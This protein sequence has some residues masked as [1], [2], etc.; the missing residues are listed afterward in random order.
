MFDDNINF[1][2]EKIAEKENHSEALAKEELIEEQTEDTP[3]TENIP[4]KEEAFET[5]P[6]S[7]F[8]IP[9]LTPK[10]LEKKAIK[11]VAQAVGFSFL[12]FYA[13]MWVLNI[14]AIL[15][16]RIFTPSFN[17]AVDILYEPAIAQVQQIVFS[18]SVFTLPFIFIFKLYKYRISDLLSFEAPKGKKSLYLFLIGISFCSFANIAASLAESI[19]DKA[20]ISYEVDFG[21]N[22]KGVFGFLLSFIATAIVPALVE[23]FACRGILLGALKKHGEAFAIITSSTLFGLMHSN[24]E[25]IPFAFLVGLVLGYITIKSGNIWIAVAVHC[26]NNSVSVVYTYLLSGLSGVAQNISYT[27]FLILCLLAGLF[28]ITRL[29][30]ENIFKFNA[31]TAVT[32]LTT[33]LKWFFFSVPIII[34]TSICILQSLAYFN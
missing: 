13:I 30:E 2:E 12:V 5:E 18:L 24:F 1:N 8:K 28:A 14:A 11:K 7:F 29:K 17:E 33:R 4:E 10:E 25:Q 26:F 20:G 27:V 9:E 22:P 3:E 31:D 16:S 32:D 23:E 34:Y 6:I 19:F 21:D 15:I